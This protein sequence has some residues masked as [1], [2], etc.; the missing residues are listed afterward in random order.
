MILQPDK[1]TINALSQ[2]DGNIHFEQVKAWLRN[3]LRVLHEA[4]PYVNDEVQLRW[5]QGAEQVLQQFLDKADN[6]Q[7]TIRKFSS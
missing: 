1:Q 6:A 5:Q 4:T 2:L 7:E 3:T